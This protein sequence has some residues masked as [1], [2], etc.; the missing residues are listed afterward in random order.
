M[1]ASSSLQER[2]HLVHAEDWEFHKLEFNLIVL[3]PCCTRIPCKIYSNSRFIIL[4]PTPTIMNLQVKVRPGNLI[5]KQALHVILMQR[6]SRSHMEI[7][8]FLYL[9]AM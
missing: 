5:F 2:I 8:W 4:S 1:M 3:Q 9:A 7:M 6:W